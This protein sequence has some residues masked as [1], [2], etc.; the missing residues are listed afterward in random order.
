MISA[1][2][3]ILCRLSLSRPVKCLEEVQQ[4]IFTSYRM[5][6]SADIIMQARYAI[7]DLVYIPA[8][9]ILM[10]GAS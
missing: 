3:G 10:S 6:L 8:V 9:I 5:K 1:G 2:G 7:L 4:M